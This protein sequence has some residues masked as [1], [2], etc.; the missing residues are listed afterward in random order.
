MR[1]RTKRDRW[2][3]NLSM[4]RV[5]EP[6]LASIVGGETYLRGEWGARVFGRRAPITLELGCGQGLF[7][8]DLARRHP[9]RDVVGVDIKG[10]RFW[11]GAR[12]AHDEGIRNA[13]FLRARIQWLDRFFAPGEVD[14]IWLTFSDPQVGDKRGTKRLTSAHYLTLYQGLLPMGGAVRVK[15]DS[16]ELFERTL[17]DARVAGMEVTGVSADVH[18]GQES[19]F[20]DDLAAALAFR[21]AYEERWLREGRTVHYVGLMKV[22][23]VAPEALTA[24]RRLLRGPSERVKPRFPG[25]GDEPA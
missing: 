3:D 13:A 18:R 20:D 4:E 24:S 8:I 19:P 2:Q 14:E 5:H 6:D 9:E 25:V 21:T 12:I 23:E 22:A 16:P 11:R 10:H 15:S 17:E 7:A 1:N